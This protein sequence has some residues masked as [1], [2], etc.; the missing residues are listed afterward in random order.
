MGK[1]IVARAHLLACLDASLGHARA[2]AAFRARQLRTGQIDSELTIK[3][4]S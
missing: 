4:S 1:R 2:H 3:V